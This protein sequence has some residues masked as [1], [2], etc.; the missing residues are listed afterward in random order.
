MSG[1]V[2]TG[3]EFEASDVGARLHILQCDCKQEEKAS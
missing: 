2:V 1:E 3:E